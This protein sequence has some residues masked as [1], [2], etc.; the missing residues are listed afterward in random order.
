MFRSY[1]TQ[2]TTITWKEQ[3]LDPNSLLR[4][5]LLGKTYLQNTKIRNQTAVP[6]TSGFHH[7]LLPAP[8]WFTKTLHS[9]VHGNPH[10]QKT[11]TEF[12][13]SPCTFLITSR[14]HQRSL[15][16]TQKCSLSFGSLLQHQWLWCGLPV[17]ETTSPTTWGQSYFPGV[18][19]D[20]E[21]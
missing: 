2:T 7:S 16:G 8:I 19:R 10:V 3:C 4:V 1:Q 14:Q 5:Q 9:L 18:W 15:V 20:F 11:G 12:T 6:Q 17:T 21:E 13:S